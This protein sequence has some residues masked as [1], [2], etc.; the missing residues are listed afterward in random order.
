VVQGE[1]VTTVGDQRFEWAPG[2]FFVVPPWS[3]HHH[4]SV[5]AE[6]AI[7]SRWT[8]ARRS[9]VSGCTGKKALKPENPVFERL[10]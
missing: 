10:D 1:G 4:E 6:D 5:G 2:D 7:L 9:R 8:T 3:W